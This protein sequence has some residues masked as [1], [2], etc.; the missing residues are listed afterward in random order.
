MFVDLTNAAYIN[1]NKQENKL[2][3]NICAVNMKDIYKQ[4]TISLLINIQL[5]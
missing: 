3:K 5:K 4:F 2:I 1:S